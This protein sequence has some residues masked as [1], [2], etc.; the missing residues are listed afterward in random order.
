MD[1]LNLGWIEQAM[2]AH[3]V[4][5]ARERL[6]TGVTTDSR[7]VE[8][9]QLFFALSGEQFDG[10]LFVKQAFENGACAAVVRAE[11]GD[12]ERPWPGPV[13]LVDDS[14]AALGRLAAAYRET[15]KARVI[16]ITGSVGKTTTKDMIFAALEGERE[17]VKA[18]RSF[19]NEIG[20]PLTLLSA[21]RSSEVV[22]VEVGTNAPGEIAALGAIAKPDIVALTGIGF[23]HL[24]GLHS[25]S[26]VGREKASILGSLV[27]GGV[28]FFNGDD[29]R[30]RA[31]AAVLRELKGPNASYTVG[32]QEDCDWTGTVS[33]MVSAEA[34][35]RS[36]V[37]VGRALEI[38]LS[39]PGAHNLRNALMAFAIAIECG[40]SANTAAQNLSRF[41]ASPGRLNV[42][43]TGAWTI[44]DDCY[45]ANPTS[46]RAALETF[47]VFASGR[48]RVAVLGSMLELGR[49]SAHYHRAIGRLAYR[50]GI[51]SL[52]TVGEDARD[53][54]REALRLGFDPSRVKVYETAAEARFSPLLHCEEGAA[55]L[56]K[57]SR[58]VGLEVVVS[59]L[60]QRTT[61]AQSVLSVA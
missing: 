19:N 48:R 59:D 35:S 30:C 5:C 51:D 33:S 36:S 39:I 17:V 21:S 44:L 23:S 47:T 4:G 10:R 6:V 37:R 11:R 52:L 25:L 27:P 28:A 42:V 41:R 38:S 49:N 22:I 32:F 56:V 57:G 1:P 24:K 61:T 8:K 58:A 13:L 54:A 3:R 46:M 31:M 43:R 45:N 20:V 50:Y 18:L 26:E 7:S 14:T 16:C 60:C 53:I 55:I 12:H 9:G 40:L 34:A 2:G 29:V 15:L